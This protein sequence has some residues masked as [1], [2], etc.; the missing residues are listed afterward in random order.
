[1]GASIVRARRL[2]RTMTEGERRLWAELRE[3]RRL[4]GLHARKQVPIGPYV[5][6]FVIHSKSLIIEVDGEHHALPDRMARD[7]Q[8]DDWLATKGYRILR[9]T[10]GEL[11]PILLDK[12]EGD[13]LHSAWR[14]LPAVSH[15]MAA[16]NP[17]PPCGEGLGAGVSSRSS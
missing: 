4:Y 15:G 13:W 3:F 10:T 1:M 16:T 14:I 8:R 12:G 6:D 17:P 2:R 7:A 11:D 9:F 5:A